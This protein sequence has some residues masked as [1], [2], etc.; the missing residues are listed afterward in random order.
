[1][2]KGRGRPGGNPDFG[3]KYK[4]DYGNKEKRDVALTIRITKTMLQQL[5]D[6][7]GDEYR[8]FCRDV[9]A[10]AIEGEEPPKQT[11]TETAEQD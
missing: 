9:I 6:I 11:K 5:K 1:M 2:G 4:F 10:A 8:N 7:A 3:T